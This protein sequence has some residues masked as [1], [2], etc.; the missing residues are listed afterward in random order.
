MTIATK[1]ARR[2][3]MFLA[4]FGLMLSLGM[5]QAQTVIYYHTDALG[6]PAA[7]TD[8]SGN[9]IERSEYEPYGQLLNRPVSDGPGYAGHVSDAVTGLSYMQQRYYDPQIGRFLSV[10]PITANADTG[11]NFNR[12]KY[13]S[14]NPYTFT[15]PDGRQDG[16]AA[17]GAG[18]AIALRNHPE[19][20][21]MWRRSEESVAWMEGRSTLHGA[22]TADA[23]IQF[24]ET[25]D[26][27]K[28]AVAM[29]VASVFVARL[30]H[31]RAHLPRMRVQDVTKRGA[32]ERNYSV[33]WTQK[34]FESHLKDNGYKPELSKSGTVTNWIDPN[35]NKVFTTR[36]FS[37]STDGPSAEMHI[38]GEVAAKIR[39]VTEK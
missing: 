28:E 3:C 36:G 22:D 10:D 30:S 23:L 26:Y 34:Q 37:K 7:T 27:S 1:F 8:A 11:E 2:L 32:G 21:E 31:G 24:V 20:Y 19:Q 15:D 29:A 14:G 4:A 25:G 12:Y 35:G 38:N 6:S 17:H 39:F 13:A 18:V 16:R 9:V 5:A 33:N